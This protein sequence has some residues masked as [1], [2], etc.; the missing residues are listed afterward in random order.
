[1]PDWYSI[2]RD[3]SEQPLVYPFLNLY[4]KFMHIKRY[5]HMPFYF[6]PSGVNVVGGLKSA[7]LYLDWAVDAHEEAR[8]PQDRNKNFYMRAI[9]FY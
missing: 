2:F 9:Y 7:Q 4:T 5:E 1:M 8:N 6:Y 3:F